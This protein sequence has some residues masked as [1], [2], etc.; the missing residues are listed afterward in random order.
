MCGIIGIFSQHEVVEEIYQGL[1]AIQHR[2]QDSAGIVT[3]DDR[4]H[5]KKGNGLTQK[6]FNEKNLNR[7]KGNIGIGHVRYPTVGRG[8]SE[9]A[10][11]FI[12]NNPFGLALAHNGNLV[13]YFSLKKKLVHDRFRYLSS[14]CDAEVIL[15][16][17][18]DELS[19]EDLKNFS[20]ELLFNTLKG[21][22][23]QLVGSFAAVTVIAEKGM[24]AFRDS[25]GIKPLVFGTRGGDF[26][27]ASESVAFDLLGYNLVGDV[28]PGEAIFI[29]HQ[30]Q[31]HRAQIMPAR[32]ATC[33]FE[34]VY[35]ARPDSI[36]DE[37]SVYEARFRLGEEL[38]K[39][40]KQLG[41]KP[42]VV[43][44]VP[45]TARGA[46]QMVAEILNVEHREGLIK[47]RYIG[48]TFIMP[49]PRMRTESIR[50]KMNPIKS[51]IANKKVLI[52]DD[53]IVRGNTAKK[54]VDLIRQSGA[55]EV[56]YA[57]YSPPLIYPCVYGIDMQTRREFI[58]RE[59][60][61]EE[62]KKIIGCDRLVY[63]TVEGLT[64]GVGLKKTDFCMGCFTGQYP[65]DV[66]EKAL[67]EIEKAR[68]KAV[69][70]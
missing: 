33:I 30:R 70:T 62:I 61:I 43:I 4:L 24:M 51:V 1:L 5:L 50:L 63:Q 19:R 68:T 36:I 42:D 25:C 8:S 44:P 58:A 20:P 17:L 6:V 26:A 34:Y 27:F 49:K 47:N 23:Q 59:K 9:D 41:L 3:F 7:L 67:E 46:A 69:C 21:V 16:V 56:Y 52:I 12:V 40:C 55:R 18:A 37:I 11:P 13:N 60:S 54:I 48:R 64:R 28:K 38:G 29:D 57:S 2:G 14:E 65:T 32:P 10:Q 45:D 15:N 66:P 35:F 39:V 22:Y 31:V 53:S